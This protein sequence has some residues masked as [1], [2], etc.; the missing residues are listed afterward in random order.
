M[1]PITL[2]VTLAYVGLVCWLTLGTVSNHRI[3][4]E[5]PGGVLN[6]DA[7]LRSAT[8]EVGPPSEILANIVLFVPVGVLFALVFGRRLWWLAMLAAVALTATIEVL[9]IPMPDRISDPRDLVANTAG[10]VIGLGVVSVGWLA[11]ALARAI[12]RAALS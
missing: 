2:L 11:S 7:W 10:A 1:R 3:G 12:R 8:W 9:Q 6:P 5:V 4:Y